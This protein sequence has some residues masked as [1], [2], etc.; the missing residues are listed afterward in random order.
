MFG[1]VVV[2]K[3]E[4]KVKEYERYRSFYCGLCKTLGERHGMVS[5]MSLSYDMT[6]LAMLLTALYE[7]DTSGRRIFCAV[8]PMEKKPILQNKYIE[9]AAD[10]TVLLM[11]HK[12]LDD[13][14]DDRS[15]PAKTM[16]LVLQKSYQKVAS[17]YP[18]KA[19]HL[20]S[21]MRELSVCEGEKHYGLE[22]C[23][24]IF[25]RLLGDLFVVENDVWAY[26]LNQ[27][28]Y[29]IGQFVYLADAY[30]DLEE[31]RQHHQFNP[32]KPLYEQM[33]TGNTFLEFD[34]YIEQQLNEIMEQVALEFERLPIIEDIE[35]LRNIIY[36]GVW[37]KFYEARRHRQE[38]QEDKKNGPV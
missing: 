38:K 34:A 10:V 24:S 15:I 5:K 19:R 8:H 11:Y 29:G 33:T 9:Y 23:S 6:F 16:T 2:H 14:V 13:W 32:L 30:V 28:G 7:P 21:C 31:D 25:G 37:G 18:Q 12:L 26:S 17:K 1:H 3:D 35:I 36:A 27:I 4:L 20:E 22:E